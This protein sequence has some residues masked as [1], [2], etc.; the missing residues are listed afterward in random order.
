VALS[1]YAGLWSALKIVSDIADASATVA[2]PA[3]GALGIPAPDQTRLWHPRTLL[4]PGA[5]EAEEDLVSVRIPRVHEYTELAGLNRIITEPVRPRLA[6]LASGTAYAA[7]RRALS[8]LGLG[9]HEQDDLGLRLVKIDL[10]WPL[11]PFALRAMVHRV[12]E[13][14]VVEDKA[15][16][17]EDQLKSA[18]YRQPSQP[19][20]YGKAD[21]DG[22]PLIPAHGAVTTDLVAQALARLWRD[23]PLP[24]RT[25][26][27]VD[28]HNVSGPIRI[29][30]AQD[31]PAPRTPYF[32]SGCPHNISTRADDDQ[33]VGLG[34][35]CHIMAA[36]DDEGRGHKIGMTQ[37]GGEGAQWI[38]MSPF[39]DDRH[40][41]QNL[42]DGTFFHSGSLAV[43]GAVA[44]GVTMTYKILYNDAV[45]MTGGQTPVG[46]VGV[47]ELTHW[48]AMEGV[49]KVIITTPDPSELARSDLHPIAS[50]VHRDKTAEAQRELAGL[51]G[52]TALIHHD[53]CAAEERRLRNRGERPALSESVWINSR[54]C[55]GCGDCAEHATC[56]SLVH[57]DTDFG[58]KMAIHQG[59]CNLDRSC[60]KGECPSFVIARHRSGPAA[61]PARA[62]PEP[63]AALPDPPARIWSG[64]TVIRMPGIGGTGVVTA[65]RI[66]QM[67]AHLMGLHAAGIDQTG[68]AQKNGPVTS[69]VR[70][71][72]APITGDVHASRGRAD[73]LLG[74]DLL[75]AAGDDALSVTSPDHTVAVLNMAEVPTA[76][77][78]RHQGSPYPLAAGLRARIA[79]STRAGE[80]VCVDAQALAEQLTGDHLAANL[81][82]MGAA[83]QTGLFPFGAAEL[84]EAIQLNGVDIPA[85]LAAVAWGRAA[86]ARPA[87]VALALA[88]AGPAAAPEP[89][90]P[91]AADLQPDESWPVSLQHVIRLRVAELV[92]FQSR[93]VAR[94]YLER[95][96]D[97]ARRERSAC[98][99]AAPVLTETFA[100]G[101]YALTAVKDEYEVARLHLLD[102]E[103]ASF[104][105]SFPGARPAY[106]LKPPLL[107]SLGLRRKITL[108]RSAPVAFHLLRAGRHLRGTPFDLF[109]W[110]AERRKERSFRMEYLGWVATALDHLTPANAEVARRVV[111]SANDVHGYAHVRQASIATVRAAAVQSLA[112]LTGTG[113]PAPVRAPVAG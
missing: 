109:G 29:D 46:R 17:I 6:I 82:L 42:G 20:I 65:S 77:M 104:A 3:L 54:V 84:A 51:A 110:S 111:Q 59:S 33:L 53:P 23:E 8:D 95:V 1:R 81:V 108:V 102:E 32:C 101:W 40:Y 99:D 9:P 52:V 61:A 26:R 44:A 90:W 96:V 31:S 43:R 100:R 14:L 19:R 64:T 79:R 50:V 69:D 113:Q 39:T 5:L 93:R 78:L 107:A 21:G 62:Y 49:K 72:R 34:I 70:I 89:A 22:A 24:D 85:S 57:L 10:P 4:G 66:V 60:V 105:R 97:V 92:G 25:R 47:P 55:E 94:D 16:V 71:S 73:L 86:V 28:R 15:P 38:G 37:M 45:A 48:L 68:L 87:L 76:T 74:F 2:I 112:E 103:R 80:M 11:S 27:A 75:G 58:I 63:P 88:P 67:S 13:V 18:L 7:T 35:G 56:M 83:F 30:L 36:L 91:L 106:L 12:P 41:A 98:P